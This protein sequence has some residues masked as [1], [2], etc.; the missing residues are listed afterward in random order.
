MKVTVDLELERSR[1]EVWE[2][3][4]SFENLKQW[5]PS[6]VSAEPVSGEP[7]QIGAVSKLTYDENGREVVLMETI[8]ARERPREFG[9]IYE[10]KSVINRIHNRFREIGDDRTLWSM[11]SEF[12]FSGLYRVMMFFMRGAVRKQ[13]EKT[14]MSFKTYLEGS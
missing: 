2:K 10:G 6:L 3:F 5:Q 9:G 4:D 13:T 7:G 8:T 11:D 12:E 1:E 14:M